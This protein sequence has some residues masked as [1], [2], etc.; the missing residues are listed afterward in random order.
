VI[1][2]CEQ[3]GTV[4]SGV[5]GILAGPPTKK[6]CRVVEKCDSCDT[7]SSDEAAGLWY[8]KLKGGASRY[9]KR[10]RVIWCPK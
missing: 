5:R 4:C 9:D 3:D 2:V 10:T 7:F 1:C 8:A 6:G